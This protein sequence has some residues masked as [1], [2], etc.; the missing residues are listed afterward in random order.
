LKPTF[1]ISVKPGYNHPEPRRTSSLFLGVKPMPGLP[2]V[3]LRIPVETLPADVI[4]EVG[5]HG[6]V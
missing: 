2:H 6:L 1:P 4:A 3:D 5:L